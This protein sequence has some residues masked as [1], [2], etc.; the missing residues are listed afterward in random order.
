MY[1]TLLLFPSI[2]Q[3]SAQI[4]GTGPYWGSRS[5]T[6][7]AIPINHNWIE[8]LTL[9]LLKVTLWKKLG[10]STNQCTYSY[11]IKRGTF[12]LCILS[13]F[14]NLH[15][16]ISNEILQHIDHHLWAK[17]PKHSD[18]QPQEEADDQPWAEKLS[19]VIICP[20]QKSHKAPLVWSLGLCESTS[21]T[22]LELGST[23]LID[24][25]RQ[26]SFHVDVFNCDI[27][28]SSQPATLC[29]T[30]FALHNC[31][32]FWFSCPSTLRTNPENG[33]L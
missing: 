31:G 20:E 19:T 4:Y 25:P 28:V 11:Q 7:K 27:S 30:F 24:S 26:T 29:C 3:S 16:I 18:H 12:F 32:F 23:L 15:L 21:S 10:H 9:Y 1:K 13:Y 6:Q 2:S 22:G 17:E 5:S 33:V 14:C 8:L